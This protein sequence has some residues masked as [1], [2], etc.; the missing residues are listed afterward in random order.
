MVAHRHILCDFQTRR[1]K[2]FCKSDSL[3]TE[4]MMLLCLKSPYNA[5]CFRSPL[6]SADRAYNA[7]LLEVSFNLIPVNRTCNA[8][9]LKVSFNLFTINR[10]H[11]TSFL[12]VPFNLPL[13]CKPH[14]ACCKCL[15][16]RA[17]KA[18]SEEQY[19]L[20]VDLHHWQLVHSTGRRLHDRNHV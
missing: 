8:S 6:I 20:N 17:R 10:A 9:L 11:K 18:S 7:S 5:L 1:Q 13:R 12:L 15:V 16:L 19:L 3:L 2:N 14:S 4:L